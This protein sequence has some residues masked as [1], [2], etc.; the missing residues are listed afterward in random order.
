M[1]ANP[2]ET[3]RLSKSFGTEPVLRNI[4][5]RV[6]AG[7]ALLVYGRNGA[8]KSTLITILAGLLAPTDG[9]AL[10]FGAPSNRLGPEVR[11]R[12]GLLTHQSF[13]YPNLTAREN[14]AFFAD[15]YRIRDGRALIPGWIERVGLAASADERVRG[16]SRGMEQRLAWARVMFPTPD[17]L[18]VDEPFNALDVEGVVVAVTLLREALDRGCAVVMTAHEGVAPAGLAPE[19]LELNRGRL[20]P[21]GTPRVS[22]RPTLVGT[23]ATKRVDAA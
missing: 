15:L 5:I 23:S 12:V 8:G 22:T 6:E 19:V 20:L 10:L 3:H 18:L 1:A 13:L 4:D 16:F 14:L 2:I 11:R 7:H 17:V 21:L 9:A